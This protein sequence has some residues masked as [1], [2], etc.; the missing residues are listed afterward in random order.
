MTVIF[1]M[2]L[3][4]MDEINLKQIITEFPDCI[5]NGAKLKAILLDTYPE[6]SKG[7]INAILIISNSGIA[8]EIQNSANIDKIATDRWLKKLENDYCMSGSTVEKCL[9][10]WINAFTQE[11]TIPLLSE[12]PSATDEEIINA[13][14]HDDT[15]DELCEG[16]IDQYI[17]YCSHILKNLKGHKGFVYYELAKQLHRYDLFIRD[18]DLEYFEEGP[19][20]CKDFTCLYDCRLFS[21][22]KPCWSDIADSVKAICTLVNYKTKNIN[23]LI[24]C[25]LQES[26][27]AKYQP[28]F[29][30]LVETYLDENPYALYD[31]YYDEECLNYSWFD[32]TCMNERFDSFKDG[33]EPALENYAKKDAETA[34][35]FTIKAFTILKDKEKYLR[36][37]ISIDELAG[38]YRDIISTFELWKND[39][40]N[41]KRFGV[42]FYKT[43]LPTIKQC[44]DEGNSEMI[45]LIL[46]YYKNHDI[47]NYW[48]NFIKY[49]KNGDYRTQCKIAEFYNNQFDDMHQESDFQEAS[50]WYELAIDNKARDIDSLV[51][52]NY[53]KMLEQYDAK[54]YADKINDLQ[55]KINACHSEWDWRM[56]Y[57]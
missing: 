9:Q 30:A 19:A 37:D 25:L 53:K 7:I 20:Y 13:I 14:E 56:R 16:D 49:G 35:S 1:N 22:T 55:E 4:I 5:T 24:E 29:N 50:K 15:L 23:I 2:G 34:I 3:N 21:D 12:K 10:L 8:K 48:S 39:S 28:A 46:D 27:K 42:D 32:I 41:A 36:E 6:V 11:E 26:L 38:Y 52:E 54:K 33:N 43:E 40:D 51:I 31:S 45:G 47:A 57:V 18:P 17:V 44:A